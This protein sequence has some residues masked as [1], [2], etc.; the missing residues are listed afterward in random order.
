MTTW[1]EN[2]KTKKLWTMPKRDT[3]HE[4]PT[5]GWIDVAKTIIDR[6][7]PEIYKG[8][9]LTDF[10]EAITKNITRWNWESA[11]ITGITGSGKTYLA[12]AISRQC[13]VPQHD[14]SIYDN[15]LSQGYHPKAIRFQFFPDLV[16]RIKS[17]FGSVTAETEYSILEDLTKYQVLIIDDIGS[18][19]QSDFSWTTL[20]L[21]INKRIMDGKRTIITTNL[22]IKQ[23]D[24]IEPRLASRLGSFL[25]IK[26]PDVDRRIE[27][28]EELRLK[29]TLK[30]KGKK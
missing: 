5:L 26:M 30:N 15:R 1:I 16:C 29:I 18:E 17:T 2:M 6:E 25:Q 24:A 12:N 4:E 10:P 27:K 14:G 28:G 19:K 23:I 8:S 3:E 7:T 21:L 22:G 13:L 20:L 9:R 11:F